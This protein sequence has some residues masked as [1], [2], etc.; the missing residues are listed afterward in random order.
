MDETVAVVREAPLTLDV[1]GVESYTLLCTP[2]DELALA[3]GF[4]LSEGIIDSMDDVDV[5]KECDDDPSVIRIGLVQRVPRIHDA[6]RNLLIVSSCG[7][8]G[9]SGLE[10]KLRALPEVGDTFRIDRR[11][12]RT[13]GARLK[14]RQELFRACG[15]THAAGVFDARGDLVSIAEDA[16]RHNALDKAIGRCLRDGRSPAGLAAVLSSRVSVEMVGK[17]ARA[18]LELI[19]A[20]SAPTSLAIETAERCG[21]TL[22][23]FVRETRATVFTHPQRVDGAG[24]EPV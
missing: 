15:G 14:D 19:C 20:I 9:A 18:G 2:G 4:L 17:S 5:L 16:G 8:C 7:L 13:V 11:V 6:D 3:V 22:C 12:L 10:S 24:I 1:Q 21:I 23:S